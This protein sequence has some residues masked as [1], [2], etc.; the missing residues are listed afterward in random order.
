[1]TQTLKFQ[2]QN[3]W[4]ACQ[5]WL[6]VVAIALWGILLLRYWLTGQLG[7][8]IHPNYNWLTVTA[9]FAL[10]GLAGWKGTEIWQRRKSARPA[11][12]PQHITLL[13]NHTGS[14]LLI[15]TALI[16]LLITPRAFASQT[17]IQ[18]GVND[19]ITLTQ[20][21]PQAFR[22]VAKP[23]ERT[24]IEWV[25]TFQVYPEPDAY[26]GQKA[27]VQGFVV[28]PDNLPEQYFLLTRFI[29][30]C[31]AADAYPVSLPIKLTEGNRRNYKVDQWFEVEGQMITE[32]LQEG[33][34]QAVVQSSSSLIR[35]IE[36]PKNPY[37]Y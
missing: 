2:P 26:A 28:H 37:L 15:I 30:T 16:G 22:G 14:S 13:P 18:R 31:C 25:R 21:K 11:D 7:L 34:R 17:A 9:A 6:D 36:A 35:P 1:M 23:E 3:L 4:K 12:N 29:I 19:A 10:L 32:T 33:K 20:V 8:L 5:P 27:K 24:L